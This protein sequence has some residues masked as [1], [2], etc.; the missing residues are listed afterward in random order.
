MGV[1]RRPRF[2]GV[3]RLRWD[4]LEFFRHLGSCDHLFRSRGRWK[5]G[6][7]PGIWLLGYQSLGSEQQIFGDEGVFGGGMSRPLRH[8]TQAVSAAFG[9]YD[10][11]F[12]C[13][14]GVTPV[15]YRSQPQATAEWQ[16]DARKRG[17]A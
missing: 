9:G 14:P 13:R 16:R 8:G 10:R 2:R 7:W 1:Q 12:G 5:W 3:L 11:H 15:S 17:P 6:P 4:S